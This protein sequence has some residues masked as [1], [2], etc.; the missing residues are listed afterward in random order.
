M[1]SYNSEEYQ[2]LSKKERRE[3]KKQ[4]K[5]EKQENNARNRLFK[6]IGIITAI[7]AVV[8]LIIWWGIYKVNQQ[9]TIEASSTT[10][11]TAPNFSLSATTGQNISLSDY[12]G[13][14]NV[15]IYF[16]EG[17]SCDPCMQQIPELEKSMDDFN[18]LNVQLLAVSG[19]DSIDQLKQGVERFGIKQ[20]PLLSYTNAATEVDYNLLPYSMA[21][22]RR[23][24]H[25]FVLVDKEGKIIWRKDYWDGYGMMNVPNG[26]MFVN[27]SEI[28]S[29]V[30]KALNQ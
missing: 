28:V 9:T 15:L 27:S 2:N 6:R 11:A 1:Y 10:G 29:E 26:K 24:G 23:A 21:M 5:L 25:T 18:K 20:I 19:V 12:K 16:H 30:K 17:L 14:K 3:L 8:G 7:I 13:K 4:F 22:G